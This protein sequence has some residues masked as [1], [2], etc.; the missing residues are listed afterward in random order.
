M[1]SSLE[2]SVSGGNVCLVK[3]SISILVITV[4]GLRN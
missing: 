3:E 2:K 1:A 4:K